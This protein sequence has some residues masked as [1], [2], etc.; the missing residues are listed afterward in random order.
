MVSQIYYTIDVICVYETN[1]RQKGGREYYKFPVLFIESMRWIACLCL[2]TAILHLLDAMFA[3]LDAAASLCAAAICDAAS[4]LQA[5]VSAAAAMLL[6]ICWMPLPLAC[7]VLCAAVSAARA[8]VGFDLLLPGL[9]G[10]CVGACV[11][12]DLLLLGSGS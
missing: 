8:C 1:F 3:M 5:A 4:P 11:R 10:L 6:C 7:V 9:L 12:F 2:A